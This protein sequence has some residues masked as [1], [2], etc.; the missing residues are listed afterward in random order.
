[1]QDIRIFNYPWHIAHQD[2]LMNIPATKWFWLQQYKRQYGDTP[3]GDMITRYGI[4]WVPHYESGKYDVALLHLDQ[5]CFEKSIRERGK[6]SLFDE[7]NAVIKNDIPKIVI[8]H[9]TPYYPEMFSCDI[10][11]ENYEQLG[12]SKDQIGMSSELIRMFKDAVKDFD[13]VIFNSKTAA[14]Q[15]GFTDST[16]GR[17]IWHGMDTSYWV[18]LPKEPRVVT[19]ISPAGLD[20]YYDRQFLRAVKEHLEEKSIEHCHITVDAKFRNFEEYR[21]FLGR[22]LVYFNPTRESPM[23]RSRTEAMLSGCC[24]VTTPSQDASDFIKTGE[25]GF[26]IPRNPETVAN[27]I[28]ELIFD[29]K[30]AVEIGQAGKKTATEIF[31][32]DRYT[33]EWRELLEQVISNHKKV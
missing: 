24:V 28:E 9:G 22:S 11:D 18:D 26:L 13:Y 15:W 1:M 14:K 20:M 29:Y 4:E 21:N 2:A 31:S 23:P 25:N 17:A 3:R 7:V 6:G 5:Q 16:K 19:M 32:M 27:L 33:K 12:F 30:K 10:T 8:M